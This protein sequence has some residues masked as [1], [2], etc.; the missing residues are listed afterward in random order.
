[1]IRV[2]KNS[3]WCPYLFSPWDFHNTDR[4][5]CFVEVSWT[6]DTVCVRVLGYYRLSRSTGQM[7][8]GGAGAGAV[9]DRGM[10]NIYIIR[11]GGLFPSRDNIIFSRYG[12]RYSGDSNFPE[13]YAKEGSIQLKTQIDMNQKSQTTSNRWL[14]IKT[15]FSFVPL[16]R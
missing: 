1:M 13:L 7:L 12:C 6:P 14:G 4:F 9:H 5:R 2:D 3:C 16:P 10:H 11:A 15:K 8:L